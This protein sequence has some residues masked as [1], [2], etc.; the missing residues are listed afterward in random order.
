ML[1][2][3]QL[4]YLKT[5]DHSF[6]IE[7]GAV[8]SGKTFIQILR[9]YEHIYL[10]PDNCLLL[11]SGKTSESLYDNV[12]RELLTL[13]PT[14]IIMHSNPLR[15][16]VLSKNIEIACADTHNESSWG[17]IQ[18][19]T[20][21]GWLAD[22]ITQAPKNFVKMAQAR[23]RGGGKVWSKFWTCNPDMP[24]HFIMQEYIMNDKLDLKTW[25]FTMDDNPILSPE[26][27]EELKSSY[28]GVFYDRY[29]LGLWVHAEGM[30]YDEY[31]RSVHVIKNREFPEHWRRVRAIDFGYTNPFVCLWGVVDE[32]GRLIIYDEHY[33]SKQLMKYH[34]D[35]I[36]SK[37]MGIDDKE[38]S[39]DFTVADHDAQ[40]NAEL[41]AEGV[42]TKNAKK[43]VIFGISA[44]KSRLKI[45]GDNKPRL[46]ITENCVNT[47]RE[48][49]LYRW[50]EV[51]KGNEKEE[52]LKENDHAMDALRYMIVELDKGGQPRA[53]RI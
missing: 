53:R 28:S 19:K 5:S 45:Q 34:A 30:V 49:G 15:L 24:E 44:V 43:N 3:K 46:Q 25:E 33:K 35:M 31:V 14:D 12:I 7:S 27:V 9:W 11:M 41:R 32:D 37:S 13:N 42:F 50:Q 47:I 29:I 48:V 18:G 40:D 4:D 22:E 23:C 17:R 21:C 2:D 26:Y 6:N 20:V 38:Y 51:K 52:P 39:F 16:K 36:K 10:A 8:S 1:S